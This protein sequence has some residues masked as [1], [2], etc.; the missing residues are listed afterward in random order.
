MIQRKEITWKSFLKNHFSEI[1]CLLLYRVVT[2]AW[3]E[4]LLWSLFTL[5]C[6][7]AENYQSATIH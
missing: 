6:L 3:V 5:C 4:E 2:R 1:L 7:Y